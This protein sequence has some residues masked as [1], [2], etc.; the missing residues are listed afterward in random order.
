MLVPYS[1]G[2]FAVAFLRRWRSLLPVAVITVSVLVIFRIVW[3]A[4]VGNVEPKL[5]LAT[6][7]AMLPLAAAALAIAGA[8]SGF[9]AS[10]VMIEG[11]SPRPHIVLP[12]T[13]ALGYI[14]Y[15][16]IL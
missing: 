4:S 2:F 1:A 13:F 14:G 12:L 10:A 3:L 11:A 16:V 7:E 5:T 8:V 9:V 6:M 15:F